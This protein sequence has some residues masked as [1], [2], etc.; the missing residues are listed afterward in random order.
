MLSIVR[1]D[2]EDVE[3]INILANYALRDDMQGALRDP[4]LQHY[5]DKNE[6]G[7]LVDDSWGWL[8]H[9]GDEDSYN[10]PAPEGWDLKKV[11]QFFKDFEDEAY[12]VFSKKEKGDHTSLPAKKERETIGQALTQQYVMPD[13]IKE[14]EFQIRRK[15]GQVNNINI[16]NDNMT[17]NISSQAAKQNGVTFDDIIKTL[18]G[19]GAK[20]RK[21]QKPVKHTPP[22]YD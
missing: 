21:Q 10:M 13:E 17:T 14:I 6:M 1:N 18:R 20:E 4:D 22:M 16:E 19:G 15:G 12:S 2:Y 5:I 9:V 3:D 11:S 8:K 7:Y